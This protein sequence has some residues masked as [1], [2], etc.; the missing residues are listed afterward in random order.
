MLVSYHGSLG[1]EG[2]PAPAADAGGAQRQLC[3]T[4]CMS[5]WEAWVAAVPPQQ[6]VLP[7]REPE[8]PL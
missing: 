3:L 6:V 5:D 2:A 8:G 7:H 1:S 4:L